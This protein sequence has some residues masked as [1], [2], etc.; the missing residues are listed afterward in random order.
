MRP[1]GKQHGK[2]LAENQVLEYDLGVWSEEQPEE[3]D[4][5]LQTEREGPFRPGWGFR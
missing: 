5:G 4:E 2:L 3:R 1:H